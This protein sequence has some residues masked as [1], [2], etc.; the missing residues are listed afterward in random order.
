MIRLLEQSLH[1]KL[2]LPF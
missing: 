1:L 2:Y